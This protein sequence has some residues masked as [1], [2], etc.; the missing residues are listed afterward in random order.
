MMT[1]SADPQIIHDLTAGPFNT[2]EEIE[3]EEEDFQMI[4]LDT[5]LPIEEEEFEVEVDFDLE[6]ALDSNEEA[7]EASEE[8]QEDDLEEESVKGID[9]LNENE[10]EAAELAKALDDAFERLTGEKLDEPDDE[11][12]L[13]DGSLDEK[14][15]ELLEMTERITQEAKDLD[16]DLDFLKENQEVSSLDNDSEGEN[17]TD[18]Q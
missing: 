16:L 15:D 4:D 6:A 18:L 13:K 1:T 2:P 17:T 3:D 12:A 5:G 7:L 14:E 8:T 9:L 11:L 10:D